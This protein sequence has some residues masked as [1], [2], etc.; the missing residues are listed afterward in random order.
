MAPS[1]EQN[2]AKIGEIHATVNLGFKRLVH[3]GYRLDVTTGNVA[4]AVE[5]DNETS[6]IGI[7]EVLKKL[8]QLEKRLEEVK[9]GKGE[10]VRKIPP[11]SNKELS[12]LMEM[13]HKPQWV[14]R[15]LVFFKA[16]LDGQKVDPQL[17]ECT[18]AWKSSDLQE[19][20]VMSPEKAKISDVWTSGAWL[21]AITAPMDGSHGGGDPPISAL[22]TNYAEGL[23]VLLVSAMVTYDESYRQHAGSGRGS[24]AP[25]EAGE[26]PDNFGDTTVPVEEVRRRLASLRSRFSYENGRKIWIPKENNQQR[27]GMTDPPAMGR[28]TCKSHGAPGKKHWFFA[29]PYYE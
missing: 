17:M 1:Y 22:I 8:E 9:P 24:E 29:C 23:R 3:E 21:E 25:K 15:L 7:N 6:S 19:E 11:L 10:T 12:A 14:C 2:T 28:L 5:E 26:P 4:K 16:V 13:D 20:L 18:S 27:T